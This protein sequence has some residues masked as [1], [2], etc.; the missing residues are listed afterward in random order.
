MA[1]EPAASPAGQPG[2]PA[3]IDTTRPHQAR[4]YDYWLGGPNNFAVDREAALA[5]PD[6]A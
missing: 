6:R 4:I 3:A 2:L 1:D 5:G